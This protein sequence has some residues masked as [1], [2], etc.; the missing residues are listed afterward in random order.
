ML[1]KYGSWLSFYGQ[2][3][4]MIYEDHMKR[5]RA[6]RIAVGMIVLGLLMVSGANA[7]TLTNNGALN[8]TALNRS[9]QHLEGIMDKYHKSFDV[10]TDI[11]AAGNHFVHRA[12]MGTDVTLDDDS[13]ET[14]HSGATAIKNT[15]SARNSSWGGWYFQN[16][17]LLGDDVKP[18][19][20]WG[21]YSDAGYNLSGA[22]R[23]TF[24]AKGAKGGERVEFFA[25]GT[26]R[27]TQSGIPNKPYPDSEAKV[28][29]CGRLVSP[30]YISLNNNWQA[31]T[32]D[33]TGLDLKYVIG[34]FGWVTNAPENANK[35]ITFYLDDIYYD[36]VHTDDLRFLVSFET[37]PSKQNFDK[38]LRNV[39]FSYDNAL[40][41]IAFTA[42]KDW[43]SA[44]LLADA[45]VY[46][47][48]HDRYYTDGRLRNTYQAGDLKSPPGWKA[49]DRAGTARL[50][51]WWNAQEQKWY[52]DREFVGS[53]TGNLAWVMNVF[54]E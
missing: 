28:T 20:N 18:R 23:L 49:N 45:F 1:D 33:L 30:C 21:D 8:D 35:D 26:G 12:M 34:G 9:Y 2:V 54:T 29:L 22:T 50:P 11:G 16:G 42:A 13:D 25:F 17:I 5:R 39:A 40:S 52:E 46:A 41:L 7:E 3:A 31:Y 53:G 43:D 24:W 14:V 37:I 51:G 38:V 36:K 4:K 15:F 48:E 47:Q 19:E 44:K 10:Y 32:I 6:L 27:N